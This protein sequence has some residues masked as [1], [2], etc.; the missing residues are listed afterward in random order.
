ME[1]ESKFRRA[2]FTPVFSSLLEHRLEGIVLVGVG[3]LQLGWYISGLSGWICPIK[4]V[5]GIPCPGCG[6]T[7]AMDE[8]LHGHVFASLRTHVFASIFLAAFIIILVSIL[9]PEKQREK[10]I[11]AIAHLETHTGLT[12]WVL[13]GL[14]LYWVIRLF[15]LV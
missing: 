15:G 12:A 13:S 11:A 14:M 8:L 5:F 3:A 6:L 10:L 2:W 7:A 1:S 4:A 9:L